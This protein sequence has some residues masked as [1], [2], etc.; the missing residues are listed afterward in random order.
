MTQH[1]GQLLTIDEIECCAFPW[2]LATSEDEWC[3]IGNYQCDEDYCA[4]HV[5]GCDCSGVNGASLVRFGETYGVWV[6]F[7]G[8]G[9]HG[10]CYSVTGYRAN[11]QRFLCEEFCGDDE[12]AAELVAYA[13]PA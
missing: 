8:M 4:E 3:D 10:W 11:I 13:V 9:H 2:H 7:D 5:V 12:S 1:T 6:T